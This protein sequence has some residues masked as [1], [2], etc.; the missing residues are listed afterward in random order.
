[1]DIQYMLPVMRPGNAE[2]FGEDIN[3]VEIHIHAEEDSSPGIW[4]TPECS[5]TTTT[6]SG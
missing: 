4:Y 3:A 6:S 5:A 2:T 1:M